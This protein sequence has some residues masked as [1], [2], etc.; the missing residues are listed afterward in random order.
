MV[1]EGNEVEGKIGEV[2][3]YKVDVN[4]KG[5]VE[6]AVGVKVDLIAELEKLALK[7]DNQIDD[8]IV[9]IVKAALGRV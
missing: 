6:I 3:S 9:S 8:K 7:S 4:D 5:I 1:L 2:G